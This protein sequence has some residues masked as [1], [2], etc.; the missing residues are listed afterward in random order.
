MK[1]INPYNS[2]SKKVQKIGNKKVTNSVAG[3]R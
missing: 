1:M 3:K 2:K